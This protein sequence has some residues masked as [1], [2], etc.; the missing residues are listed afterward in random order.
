[1][2]R[3]EAEEQSGRAA[4]TEHFPN[5]GARGNGQTRGHSRDEAMIDARNICKVCQTGCS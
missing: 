1:M 3:V 4:L 5:C 2:R